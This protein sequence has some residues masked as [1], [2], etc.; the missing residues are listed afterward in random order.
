MPPA[1][2]TARPIATGPTD[3]VRYSSWCTAN[4]NFTFVSLHDFTCDA[5]GAYPSSDVTVDANGN[6]YGT[7]GNGGSENQYEGYGVVWEITP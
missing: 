2:C 6:L 7:T 3:V 1:I 5:D 4:D